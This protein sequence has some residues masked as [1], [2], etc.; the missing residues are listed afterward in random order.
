MIK[1]YKLIGAY[2]AKKGRL[3]LNC[4]IIVE[5]KHDNAR[6]IFGTLLSYTVTQSSSIIVIV[7]VQ[8]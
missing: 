8:Q 5:Q 3:H 2:Q 1:A 7:S 4:S 6:E